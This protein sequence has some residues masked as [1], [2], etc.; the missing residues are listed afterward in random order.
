M[1]IRPEIIKLLQE[2]TDR[3]LL[4]IGLSDDFFE[5]DTKSKSNN[6][7]VEWYQTKK[8]LHSKGNHQ[9]NQKATYWMGE[10]TCK[11]YISYGANI[12]NI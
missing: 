11:S 9:Q 12:Q 1:N 2:N 7:Q 5:Y 10:N 6:K 8:L 3:K 4:D